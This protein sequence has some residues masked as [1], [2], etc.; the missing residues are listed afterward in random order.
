MFNNSHAAENDSDHLRTAKRS[1]ADKVLSTQYHLASIIHSPHS[2]HGLIHAPTST[3]TSFR[4]T[5]S[6]SMVYLV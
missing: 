3:S 4:N 6:I 2:L 1:L 5:S